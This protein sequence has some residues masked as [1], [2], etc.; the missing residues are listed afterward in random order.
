M[1]FSDT[2]YE[3]MHEVLN[4]NKSTL[5]IGQG[6]KDQR[7][8]FGTTKNLHLKFP[9]QIIETPLSEDSI[10]GVCLGASLSGSYPI[11]THIRNDFSLLMFNQ[12]IN[13]IAKYKYVYDGNFKTPMLFRMIIGR[14]WGQGA[15]HSQSLQSLLSHIP[16]LTVIM[17]SHPQ[18]LKHSYLH[19]VN[20]FKGPVV[21]LE[22]RLLYSLNFSF[23]KKIQKKIKTN[24]FV[25]LKIK[26]GNNLTIVCSS[27]MVIEALRIQ[28]ILKENDIT[29][30]VID[31]NCISNIDHKMIINSVK[32]TRK[33]LVLDTSWKKFG[34]SSEITRII[35]EKAP[36]A[37]KKPVMI[38]ANK[39]VPCPTSQ[40]LEDYFYPNT[41]EILKGA[42]RLLGIKKK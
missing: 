27:I 29:T 12:L 40:K 34:V 15:Q 20:K 42:L 26:E 14:S 8:I 33:L 25:S 1:N 37:L 21:S 38:F 11:N 2:I 41:N 36:D 17:P 18:I 6:V 9:K 30:D 22:H 24:P 3:V 31:L 10:A 16:G 32:K 5:I 39:F 23:S 19:A 13:L 35:C 4:A 28:K 7:G